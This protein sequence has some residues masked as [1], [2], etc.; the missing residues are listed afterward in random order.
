MN[1]TDVN[2][3]SGVYKLPAE[4]LA[5]LNS[6]GLPSATLELKVEASVMLL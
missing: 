3:D 4:F 5:S 1:I 2:D 6:A